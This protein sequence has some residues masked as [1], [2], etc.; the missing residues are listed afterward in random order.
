M[1]AEN[2][3]NCQIC[4]KPYASMSFLRRH[5][6]RCHRKI[7]CNMC[8]ESIPSRSHIKEHREKKHQIIQ[9]VF[10]KYYPS[11]IDGDECL[12][13]HEPG[14]SGDSDCPEGEKCKNQSCKFSEQSH[15]KLKSKLLCNFQANCNRLNCP[16]QHTVTR[17]AFLGEGLKSNQKN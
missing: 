15:T 9:K 12:F 1:H 13:V 5:D 16:F 6:W 7:E 8:G 2:V 11:C 14:S 4:N 10:C 17:K 3:F